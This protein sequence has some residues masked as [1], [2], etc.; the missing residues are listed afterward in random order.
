[1]EKVSAA[2]L[3]T[4]SSFLGSLL[5]TNKSDKEEEDDGVEK[6]DKYD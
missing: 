4:K 1:M 2:K 5:G 6:D 3:K